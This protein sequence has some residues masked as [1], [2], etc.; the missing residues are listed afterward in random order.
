VL[1]CF[2]E[3]RMYLANKNYQLAIGVEYN[4][5]CAFRVPT[6]L[7]C[8]DENA[9]LLINIPSLTWAFILGQRHMILM[10]NCVSTTKALIVPRLER[11]YREESLGSFHLIEDNENSVPL[12]LSTAR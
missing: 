11:T 10:G 3:S 1:K 12:V 6:Y 9:A 2:L 4:W 5:P 7:S 8:G